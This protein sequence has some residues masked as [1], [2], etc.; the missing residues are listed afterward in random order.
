MAAPPKQTLLSF[1]VP[2]L[3]VSVI[4]AAGA[5][6]TTFTVLLAVHEFASVTK[7]EKVTVPP[8]VT[9][10]GVKVGLTALVLDNIAVVAPVLP[11]FEMLQE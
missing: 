7:T 4:V 10:E 6:T 2:E 1:A 5:P 11:A 3:S 9:P 8:C